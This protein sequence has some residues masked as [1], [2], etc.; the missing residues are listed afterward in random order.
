MTS[1]SAASATP[2]RLTAKSPSP[3]VL[4][5]IKGDIHGAV[6]SAA[7]F[8]HCWNEIHLRQIVLRRY[9]QHQLDRLGIYPPGGSRPIPPADR[10]AM[11]RCTGCPGRW[12]PKHYIRPDGRCEDCHA[13]MDLPPEQAA[14]DHR[15]HRST[16]SSP[17][18]IALHR[19]R[20]TAARVIELPLATENDA[21]LRA[22]IDEYRKTHPGEQ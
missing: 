16:T 4:D 11:R 8:D 3:A 6:C 7:W 22:Q 13:A 2:A 17:T 9:L 14:T 12:Y 18:A 19:L 20:Y 21:L 15:T 10:T 1:D 5:H